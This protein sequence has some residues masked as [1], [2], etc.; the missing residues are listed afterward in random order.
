MTTLKPLIALLLALA[1]IP[2]AHSADSGKSAD[3][4]RLMHADEL[5]A[6]VVKL[7]MHRKQAQAGLTDAQL[8]CVDKIQPASFSAAITTAIANGLSDAELSTALAFYRST[9]GVRF[10][11][12]TMARLQGQQPAAALT[13]EDIAKVE[14]FQATAAGEKVLNQGITMRSDAVTQKMMELSTDAI[15]NCGKAKPAAK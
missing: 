2:R 5:V 12:M 1:V 3:L 14:E 8:A 4:M 15:E 11:D 6:G 13:P 7:G 10:V 9:T